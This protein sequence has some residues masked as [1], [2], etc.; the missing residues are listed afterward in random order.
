MVVIGYYV[1]KLRGSGIFHRL[2]IDVVLRSS[3]PWKL[4]HIHRAWNSEYLERFSMAEITHAYDGFLV[5]MKIGMAGEIGCHP[6]FL[7]EVVCF[8]G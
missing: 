6:P 5:L 1:Y 7:F 3:K 4:K 2:K 8:H